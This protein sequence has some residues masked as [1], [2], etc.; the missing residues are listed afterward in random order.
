MT[1]AFTN[2]PDA[3]VNAADL[4]LPSNKFS[5]SQIKIN[6]VY[7]D[8]F[9][10]LDT[11]SDLTHTLTMEIAVGGLPGKAGLSLLSNQILN[12]AQV[13]KADPTV[14]CPVGEETFYF[15]TTP[16]TKDTPAKNQVFITL[17]GLDYSF[18]APLLDTFRDIQSI[19]ALSCV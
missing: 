16:A 10:L 18:N 15:V 2:P 19:D 17:S 9:I 12:L 5:V 6:S 13:G 8:Q 7:P 14:V 4:V 1:Y 3:Q 11:Q